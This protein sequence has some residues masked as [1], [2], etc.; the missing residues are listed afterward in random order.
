MALFSMIFPYTRL[1]I[2][3]TYRTDY[4]RFF[5][6]WRMI[7]WSESLFRRVLYPRVGLPHGLFG[8]GIPVGCRPSPPPCGG[9]GG[10]I[11]VPRTV[12]RIPMWRLRPALPTLILL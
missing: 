1:L 6:R 7:Y 8:P 2:P 5:P 9:S 4:L 12:G 10:L 11:A 3:I